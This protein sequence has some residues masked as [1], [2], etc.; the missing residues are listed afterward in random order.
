MIILVDMDDVVADW[1]SEYNRLLDIE[2]PNNEIPR[3]PAQRTFD[4]FYKRSEKHQET[5]LRVMNTSGFYRNLKPIDG[6]KQAL[7][8]MVASGHTVYLVSSPFPSNPTCASDKFD[9]VEDNYGPEWTK[10]LI[11]TM[12]KT[13]VA[14]DV[15]IDDKPHIEGQLNPSWDH[16]VY[17][18]LWNRKVKNKLRMLDWSEWK[19]VLY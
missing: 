2:D 5:I 16:I 11:L 4:L 3:T 7:N 18:Q 10:K 19:N 8:D 15:L 12:D 9:W 13:A 17:D 6:A 1:K 14:G